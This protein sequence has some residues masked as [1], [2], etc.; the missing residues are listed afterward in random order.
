[1]RTGDRWLAAVPGTRRVGPLG[2]PPIAA[3]PAVPAGSGPAVG[4]VGRVVPE[5]SLMGC[6]GARLAWPRDLCLPTIVYAYPGCGWSPDGGCGSRAGDVVEHGTF[7]RRAV[8][9][10]ERMLRIVG[11]SSECVRD[12]QLSVLENRL[13]HLEE[14][15]SDPGLVLARVLGLPTFI[16]GDMAYYRRVT[17]FVE[18]GR[19]EKVFSVVSPRRCVEQ[20]VSWLKATGRW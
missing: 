10:Q 2:R 8:E 11:V 17:L 13:Y 14:L 20:V 19:V 9:L 7:Q 15:W 1:M 6:W 18:D 3:L 16:W 4:V 5:L 12:Q